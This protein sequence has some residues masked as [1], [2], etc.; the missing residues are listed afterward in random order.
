MI[1]NFE[2]SE[3]RMNEAINTGNKPDQVLRLHFPALRGIGRY[4]RIDRNLHQRLLC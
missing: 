4:G 1:I 2:R 3:A